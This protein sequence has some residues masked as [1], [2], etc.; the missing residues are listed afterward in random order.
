MK[1]E[2]HWVFNRD[3][4]SVGPDTHWVAIYVGSNVG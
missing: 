3:N 2:F 4:D 1:K